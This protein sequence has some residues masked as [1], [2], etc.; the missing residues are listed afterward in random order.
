MKRALFACLVVA[1][2]CRAHPDGAVEIDQGD[3]V[4]CHRDDYDGT[5]DPDHAAEGFPTSCNDC[6]GTD[7]WIPA[8]EGS[9]PE[10]RFPI[11][12]G[13]HS[14]LACA[15]C[16]DPTLGSS[17]GGANTDCI[18]CHTHDKPDTDAHH[19]EVGGYSWDPAHPHNCLRC[20]PR[21][22]ED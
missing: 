14:G 22:Q 7:S 10:A 20:H 3:C 9:H 21:G 18:G 12:R 16:H 2:A 5:T 6:H 17:V 13:A 19:D 11:E 15:Q 4:T 1:A 8:L